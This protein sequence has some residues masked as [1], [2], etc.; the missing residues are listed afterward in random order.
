MSS[1]IRP[2]T[3]APAAAP[4]FLPAPVEAAAPA[5][6]PAPARAAMTPAKSPRKLASST[7]ALAP[8]ALRRSAIHAAACRSPS[9]PAARSIGASAST[10]SR[11]VPSEVR[12]AVS[13]SAEL[14]VTGREG[15]PDG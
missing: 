6:A 12:G 11:R 7:R 3:S 13:V 2:A 5:M 9:E 4:S 1:A 8:A 10:T 15:Y 14:V